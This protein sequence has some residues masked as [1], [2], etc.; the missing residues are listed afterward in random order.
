VSQPVDPPTPHAGTALNASRLVYP[1]N[2]SVLRGA[3]VTVEAG[4]AVAVHGAPGSG[5]STLLACLA[6]RL[7]PASGSIRIN[8]ERLP[9]RQRGRGPISLSRS[10]GVLDQYAALLPE[11]TLAENVALPLLLVGADRAAA[12][13]RALVWLLRLDI[14]D[15]AHT[16]PAELP[17]S[18]TQRASLARALV[19]DPLVLLADEPLAGLPP[20]V[21]TAVVRVLRS[22]ASSHGT[23]I[24]AFTRD[25]ST[26][27]A[28]HR[29]V[30]LADGRTSTEEIPAESGPPVALE[31]G[32]EAEPGLARR[33]AASDLRDQVRASTIPNVTPIRCGE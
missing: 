29:T 12:L 17:T 4:E 31:P 18:V 30:G 8:G 28:L 15:S 16:G 23:A 21:A 2:G 27:E 25:Q 9:T 6:G 33:G 10:I 19:N 7:A 20:D 24:I 3:S 22:V 11:L 14:A 1:A 13:D 32:L 5:K 26:A